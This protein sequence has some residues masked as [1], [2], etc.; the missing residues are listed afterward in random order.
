MRFS[1]EYKSNATPTPKDTAAAQLKHYLM[2]G[3]LQ[4]APNRTDKS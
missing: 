3:T 4:L 1:N 2:F